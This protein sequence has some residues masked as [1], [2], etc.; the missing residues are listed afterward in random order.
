MK[1]YYKD[2]AAAAKWLLERANRADWWTWVVLTTHN[3]D[4]ENP[5]LD[6]VTARR[7]FEDLERQGLIEPTTA[8]L[9]SNQVVGAYRLNMSDREKWRALTE[10]PGW[11]RIAASWVWSRLNDPF[12]VAM[13][14]GGFAL[15]GAF[16]GAVAAQFITKLVG[17]P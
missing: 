10:I 3:P 9:S 1:K 17:G 2:R 16:V 4:S 5:K 8:I 11:C 12:P 7:V 13:V 6:D 15:V 14:S